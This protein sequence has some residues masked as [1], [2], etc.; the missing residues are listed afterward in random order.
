MKKYLLW[1]GVISVIA[2]LIINFVE[3]F[4]LHSGK[5]LDLSSLGYHKDFG[6]SLPIWCHVIGPGAY[7]PIVF[8]RLPVFLIVWF[9]YGMI[10]SWI[11]GKIKK[12]SG[13][14]R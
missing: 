1:G 13:M 7:L 14:V 12:Q 4:V 8:L 3:L 9:V 11:Y 6:S 5:C 2:G 10:V